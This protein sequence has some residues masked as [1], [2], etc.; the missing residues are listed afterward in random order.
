MTAP[1]FIRQW[2]IQSYLK[3]RGAQLGADCFIAD[4][5]GFTGEHKLLCVGDNTFIGQV[6]IAVHDRIHIG[7]SVCV[8]DE[9]QVLSA[10]H[11]V[12]ST[13]WDTVTAPVFI[14]DHVLSLIHI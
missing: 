1:A 4:R 10:S 6:K 7:A 3:S 12:M 8:N 14:E 13:N 9:T 11:D 5:S 2:R